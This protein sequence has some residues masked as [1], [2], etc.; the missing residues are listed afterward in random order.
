MSVLLATVV[1]T[2]ALL[3]TVGASLVA[4]V[5]VT[6]AFSVAIYGSVRFVELSGD[7]R[8][9]AAIAAGALALLGLA[10]SVAAVALGIVVMTS[11]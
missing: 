7:E 4:G 9:I 8:R 5:G 10:V 11:K 2:G 6:L 1:D 3:K